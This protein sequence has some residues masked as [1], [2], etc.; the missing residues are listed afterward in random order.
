MKP[1][2]EGFQTDQTQ[3]VR[4][5]LEA[6]EKKGAWYLL[7]GLVLGVILG[8]VY[9]YLINPVVY[10]HSV[11]ASLDDHYKDIYRSTIAQVFVATHDFE[12]AAL[13]L[14][15]LEDEDPVYALGAQAQRALAEGNSAE[16]QA[17]AYLASAL[18]VNNPAA[19]SPPT[20]NPTVPATTA[21]ASIPT[22]T[23]PPL[24]PLP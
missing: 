19:V 21:P 4:L 6:G 11:P 10:T 12:R 2:P 17:L 3:K 18:Q 15:L 20:Q 5:Q 16:A 22:Q 1:H 24:T 9:S 14:A 23:L 7:T 8:L 13:R